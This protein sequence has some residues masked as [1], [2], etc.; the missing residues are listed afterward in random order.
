[1]E[2]ERSAASVE[3]AIEGALQELGVSEQEAQIEIV[4]EP[5]A[6]LLGLRSQPAIVRV[7]VL[8]G[9][10]GEEAPDEEQEEVA[11]E[12]LR[13]LLEAMELQV[14]LEVNVVDGVTY[15]D[16]WG[17][18]SSEDMGLLIGKRGHTVEALQ[19]LMRA[20]VQR[21]GAERCRIQVDVEDYRKRRRR[22]LVDRAR[23]AARR[24]MKTG[25]AEALEPMSSYERKIVHDAVAE[26]TGLETG[27]EGEEPERRVVI[28]RS[29]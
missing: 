11:F 8:A 3:E 19:E 1:M 12:F 25:K 5:R 7:R 17:S 24:V 27:S 20:A 2:I 29:R 22:Q 16:I 26:I 10:T 28:R 4:Q 9:L 6:G 23:E 21:E 18:E 14:E 13:G 15:I